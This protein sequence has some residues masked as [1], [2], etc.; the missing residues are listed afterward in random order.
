MGFPL[1]KEKLSLIKDIFKNIR[2]VLGILKNYRSKLY[3]YMLLLVAATIYQLFLT[4][5]MGNII[6][7]ALADNAR[8]L[9]GKSAILVGLYAISV[10]IGLAGDRISAKNFN[11]MYNDLNLKAYSKI[12]DS[13]WEEL[14]E[15]HSGDLITRL[16]ADVK[17]VALNT[18]RLIPMVM[19]KIVMVILAWIYIIVL[20]YTM[21]L[22]AVIVAPIVLF[23]SRVFMGKVYAS[24]V[25][26]KEIESRINSYN[27]ETFNNIQAV[28]AF[29]LGKFFYQKMYQMEADRKEADLKSNE[30]SLL[31]L[32]VSFLTEIV[33][34]FICIGWMYYRV[35]TGVISFG[36]LTVLAFLAYQIGSALKYTLNVVPDIME[37]MA[38]TERLKKLILLSDEE[39]SCSGSIV[40]SFEQKGHDK[41]V[42]IKIENMSFNYK[43]GYS[44]F[45]GASLEADPGE[46][47]AIVGPS[48]EGK[49]T[50]LRIILGIVTAAKGKVYA[51]VENETIA[52]GKQTRSIISYVPQGNTMMAGSILENMRL[53][54]QDAK[55]EEIVE[56]LKTACIYDFVEKLPDGLGHVL[57]E[58]GLGF[59]EGQNQRLSIARAL[60]KDSPVLLMD[61]ATSALDVATERKILDNI[62][63][64][65]PKKTVILTTHRPTVLSMCD[66]VYRIA[67]K[68]VSVIGQEDIKKLMDEF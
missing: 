14:T 62:M 3:F 19:S 38:S 17:S 10:L 4:S 27:K 67:D 55:E 2:W 57:G 22:V 47:I 7:I 40:E 44:V 66:R 50:M 26:I 65:N 39:E 54:R 49:T 52:L 24:H 12:M 36:Y 5:R 43:N 8:E 51:R 29:N 11:N 64:K 63:K 20:D 45:E 16:T 53:I 48:G 15:Y 59:S 9:F 25:R 42:S 18:C 28:K 13:S 61:E 41:G 32:L 23:S 21:V 34:A 37:Y 68:K 56:A 30:Y 1:R 46:I 60:L 35:H 58:S 33:G 6:D 31:S